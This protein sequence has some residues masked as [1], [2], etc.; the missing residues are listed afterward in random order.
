MASERNTLAGGPSN[1]LVAEVRR[2]LRL[3][4]QARPE[5]GNKAWA[6][7]WE[8]AAACC[9]RDE[10]A[11]QLCGHRAKR[12]PWPPAVEIAS[13]FV[14]LCLADMRASRALRLPFRAMHPEVMPAGVAERLA[15]AR[16]A[17]PATLAGRVG[18]LEGLAADAATDESGVAGV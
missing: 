9:N 16:S 2:V 1:K 4:C 5:R 7:A 12:R 18:L 14:L 15:A 8:W 17:P 13:Q 6:L 10:F 3:Y 11:Q